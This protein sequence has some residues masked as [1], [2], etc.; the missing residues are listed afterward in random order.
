MVRTKQTAHKSTAVEKFPQKCLRPR[1]LAA[2]PAT[3]RV[4]KPH[5]YHPGSV[6]QC[7]I[8]N[9][10][11]ETELLFH[12]LPFQHL[13]REITEDYKEICIGQLLH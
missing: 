9:Y 4:K 6:A 7:E 5:C 13:V 1:R 10:Q 12:K 11:K 2:G 3:G 8:H